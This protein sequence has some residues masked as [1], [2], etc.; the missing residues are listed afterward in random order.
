MIHKRAFFP[1]LFAKLDNS[2][3][4]IG[5]SES[6]NSDLNFCEK[7]SLSENVWRPVAPMNLNRNGTG[8]VIFE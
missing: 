8:A 6:N 1:S 2:I 7:Y 5:G 4:V 3:Y